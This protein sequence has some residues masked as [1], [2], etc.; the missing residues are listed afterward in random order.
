M[1]N[2]NSYFVARSRQRRQL[3]VPP[4]LTV[5]RN[6]GPVW[7]HERD[8]IGVGRNTISASRSVERKPR[9]TD[10]HRPL[11]YHG[12]Q[13]PLRRDD[14]PQLSSHGRRYY[15]RL[16]ALKALPLQCDDAG[17]NWHRVQTGGGKW[18]DEKEGRRRAPWPLL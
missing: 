10:S 17:H 16:Q 13:S 8:E 5:L 1:S 7:I 6:V 11:T 4:I 2:T 15:I 14:S 12:A 3:I 18:P 9:A